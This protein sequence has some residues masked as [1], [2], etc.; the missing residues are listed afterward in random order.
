MRRA[1][2]ALL[3]IIA[4]GCGACEEE[5]PTLGTERPEEV[6]TEPPP[7]VAVDAPANAIDAARV[8][9]LLE[10]W[11]AAQNAGDFEAYEAL[12]AE[13]FEG[14][15]RSGERTYSYDRAQWLD[16][17]RRM[18]AGPMQVSAEDVRVSSASEAAVL[19][20]EQHWSNATYS[21]VGEKQLVLVQVNDEL[22]I[23][24]EEMLDSRILGH[25]EVSAPPLASFLL[26][27]DAGA[28]Y[29][30]LSTEV[31]EALGRG[32]LTLTSR[33]RPAS[34]ARGVDPAG[35]PEP[36]RAL[37][38]AQVEAYD[39]RSRVCTGNVGAPVIVHRVVPHFSTVQHWDG[40]LG[41]SPSSDPEIAADVWELGSSG[42]ILAAPLEG[43]D[44]ER[45]LWARLPADEHP[46]LFTQSLAEGRAQVAALSAF[47]RLPAHAAIQRDFRSYGRGHTGDWDSYGSAQP[48][49][50]RWIEPGM[51]REL[52]TV[53]ARVGTDCADFNGAMW[54]VFEASSEE[55]TPLTDPEAPGFYQPR[56]ILDAD[57]D[58]RVEIVIEDGLLTRSAEGGFARVLDV[59]PPY[60]DCDC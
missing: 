32:P 21:D 56:A 17:R 16:D 29:L 37:I 53:T 50:I 18:F 55:L 46:R 31:D 57:G 60:L 45:A 8:R 4:V 44:C 3:T 43:E 40:D 22:R 27:V 28:P 41:G 30:L 1:F 6:T 52:V 39:A 58:G 19:T 35:L 10:S 2:C 24:R 7:P 34:A 12:Y 23:G 13:R 48:M 15:K 59:S 38:G 36:L 5:D 54:S 14:V 11:L 20:F 42:A 25:G 26:V 9:A 49:A 51:G 33:A 47:R